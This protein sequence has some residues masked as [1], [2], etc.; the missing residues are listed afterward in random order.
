MFPPSPSL[1]PLL[2]GGPT[3]LTVANRSGV[4]GAGVTWSDAGPYI[5]AVVADTAEATAN[6][7]GDP[8]GG[9]SWWDIGLDLSALSLGA[10][11][12]FG[13]DFDLSGFGLP[14][15]GNLLMT[16]GLATFPSADSAPDL[17]IAS[18]TST[19]R[20]RGHGVVLSATD[21]QGA[22]GNI[23]ASSQSAYGTSPNR[24]TTGFRYQVYFARSG[25]GNWRNRYGSAAGVG[26]S[27]ASGEV[28]FDGANADLSTATKHALFLKF[29]RQSGSPVGDFTAKVRPFYQLLTDPLQ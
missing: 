15:A 28:R 25:A 26:Y 4:S 12:I 22:Y 14:T 24:T 10:Q 13:W 23:R 18:A 7:V 21:N 1:G 27:T 19:K 17:T 6:T 16:F 2:R 3:R 20:F 5:Q 8:A 11:L 9:L 29:A